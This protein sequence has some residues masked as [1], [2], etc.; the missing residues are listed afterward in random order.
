MEQVGRQVDVS[1]CGTL[2]WGYLLESN[3]ALCSSKG[4][5]LKNGLLLLK[6]CFQRV[7]MLVSGLLSILL[8]L[9]DEN[10]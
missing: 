7:W 6:H 8:A 4:L 5:T 1:H 2:I 10:W 3:I 9:K